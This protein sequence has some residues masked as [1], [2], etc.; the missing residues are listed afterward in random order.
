MKERC[1]SSIFSARCSWSAMV[2]SYPA[3]MLAVR[4]GTPPMTQLKI[5]EFLCGQLYNSNVS[6]KCSVGTILFTALG[7]S[8]A[9][10]S[11]HGA[12]RIPDDLFT[13]EVEVRSNQ[14]ELF[15]HQA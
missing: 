9:V 11:L 12:C 1:K 2:V 10:I 7:I 3:A 6:W 8:V 14:T 13:D 4:Q 15:H 5:F